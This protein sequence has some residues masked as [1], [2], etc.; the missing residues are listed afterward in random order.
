MRLIVQPEDGVVPVVSGIRK[1][2]KSIDMPIFRLDHIEV[3]KAIKSAVKRGVV[4]RT[5][6]AH[7][8]S[9]GEKGLRKLEQ[10]LLA[11]GATVSRTADDLVRYHNKF[12]IVD[13][14]TLF[15]YGFNYTHLDIDRSR[16]FGIVTNNKRLV[17]EAMK[18]FEADFNRRPYTPGLKSFLVSPE[19]ARAGLAG[20]L[21]GAKEQLLIYEVRIT[22]NA[23]V[24]I[25]KERAK[26]GVMIRVMGKLQKKDL[27]AQI[28]KFP[29]KLHARVIIQD[30][31]RAF[32]GSQSLRRLELDER[33]EVGVIVTDPQIVRQ[34]VSTFESDWAETDS[35][36]KAAREAEEEK[37]KAKKKKKKKKG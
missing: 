13:E 34:L 26:A 36:K 3:D 10:R 19:N 29:G 35:G 14:T 8:N 22:D 15:V 1:A 5:L 17:Q 21:R 32:V 2:K 11:T 24:R 16:S 7:T 31:R 18:L 12:M 23:M 20:L 37:E 4:V 33:R 30:G 27:D 25:L 9:G 28:E 6:I